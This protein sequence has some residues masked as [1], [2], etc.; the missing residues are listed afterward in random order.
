M[1]KPRITVVVS[2]SV[3]YPQERWL[4]VAQVAED[5]GSTDVMVG[6]HIVYGPNANGTGFPPIFVR[7]PSRSGRIPL[8]RSW[9]SRWSC[10]VQSPPSPRRFGSSQRRSWPLCVIPV[11]VAKQLATLDIVSGGRLVVMPSVG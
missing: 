4:W 10:W 11:L 8:S 6:E 1:N 2:E 9:R 7:Y 5:A 3:Q